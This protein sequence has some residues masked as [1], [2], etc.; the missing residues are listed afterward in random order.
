VN[1]SAE[2]LRITL[3]EN[4]YNS[5]SSLNITEEEYEI[6]IQ[7]YSGIFKV[8]RNKIGMVLSTSYY[9]NFMLFMVIANTIVLCLSGYIDSNSPILQMLNNIFTYI[10]TVDVTLKIIAYGGLFF[11]EVMNLFDLFVVVVSLVESSL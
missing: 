4:E 2:D 1:C 8:I 5:V 10:F 9:D 11:E 3:T 6:Y 7:G